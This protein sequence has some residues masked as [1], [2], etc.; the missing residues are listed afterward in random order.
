MRALDL[1]LFTEDRWA[2][3]TVTAVRRPTGVDVESFRRLVRDRFGVELAGGQGELKDRLFRIG[4][5]GYAGP[6][7]MVAAMA[8]VEQALKAVGGR[9]TLGAG[10]AA[11]QEV[12]A[13]WE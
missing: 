2:S 7:D 8:A 6:L 10:V 3:P 9:C 11:A 12:W 13:A 1:T 4:H 5:M